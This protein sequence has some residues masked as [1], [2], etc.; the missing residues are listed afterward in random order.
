VR[1]LKKRHPAW[2]APGKHG[3]TPGEGLINP[4]ESQTLSV[5]EEIKRKGSFKKLTG[6][7]K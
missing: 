2:T 1:K 7:L 5:I 3:F 6:F 4:L